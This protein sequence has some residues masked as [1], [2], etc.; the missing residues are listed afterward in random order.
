METLN[1]DQ[2]FTNLSYEKQLKIEV[3]AGRRYGIRGR[4]VWFGLVLNDWHSCVF[5]F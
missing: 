4:V 5:A 1:T 2:S 3:L